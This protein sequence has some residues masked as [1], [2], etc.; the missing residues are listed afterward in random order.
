VTTVLGIA[1]AGWGLVMAVAPGLQIRRMWLR[2]SSEDVSIRYFA[3][4]L[5]GFALWVAYGMARSDWVLIVPNAVAL[6]VVATAVAVAAHLRRI[7]EP[8]DAGK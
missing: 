7:D 5:P 8:A 4:L 3:V 1:A 2:R 6:L